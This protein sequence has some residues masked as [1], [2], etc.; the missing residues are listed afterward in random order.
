MSETLLCGLHRA[1]VT[2]RGWVHYLWRF[3]T[4]KNHIF[5]HNNTITAGASN[6]AVSACK[7]DFFV[8]FKTD[9]EIYLKKMAVLNQREE[10]SRGVHD[11]V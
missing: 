10:A 7:I 8:V 3:I 5:Y 11:S 6:T 9:T 4:T 2:V 1:S